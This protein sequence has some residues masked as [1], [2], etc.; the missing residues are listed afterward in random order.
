MATNPGAVNLQ[1]LTEEYQDL[2]KGEKDQNDRGRAA[3]NGKICKRT[4]IPAENLSLSCTSRPPSK[5]YD[6]LELLRWR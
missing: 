1:K 6:V 5:L 4:S 3:D 2:Q